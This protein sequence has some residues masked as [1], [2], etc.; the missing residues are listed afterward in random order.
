MIKDSESS[1]KSEGSNDIVNDKVNQ[2]SHDQI[3][4]E[5]L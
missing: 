1:K 3:G 4:I 5:I 2:I